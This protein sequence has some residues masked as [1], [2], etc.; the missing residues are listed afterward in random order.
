MQ[1]DQ[2]AVLKEILATLEQATR[3]VRQLLTPQPRQKKLHYE[4]TPEGGY[5]LRYLDDEEG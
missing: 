2:D 3:R 1:E 4:C 5:D